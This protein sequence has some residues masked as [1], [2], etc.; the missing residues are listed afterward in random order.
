MHDGFAFG[1]LVSATPL[2]DQEVEE[3]LGNSASLDGS[4][5]A[6]THTSSHMSSIA[7]PERREPENEPTKLAW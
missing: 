2:L 1:E 5:A 3:L 6:P 4:R 7:S